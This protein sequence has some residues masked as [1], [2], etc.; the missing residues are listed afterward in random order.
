MIR[1]CSASEWLVSLYRGLSHRAHQCIPQ[2]P[3]PERNDQTTALLSHV[4]C[5]NSCRFS[6]GIWMD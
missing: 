2:P 1:F 5:R 3:H 6:Y 4:Q